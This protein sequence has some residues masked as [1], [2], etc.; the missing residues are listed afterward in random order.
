MLYTRV[1]CLY[2]SFVKCSLY[3]SLNYLTDLARGRKCFEI[4]QEDNRKYPTLVP[5][6][7]SINF[8]ECRLGRGRRVDGISLMFEAPVA[9]IDR[10]FHP[11]TS[12]LKINGQ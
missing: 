3:K 11:E 2:Q 6:I 4:I 7:I 12:D 5:D 1:E 9:A 8:R 10:S